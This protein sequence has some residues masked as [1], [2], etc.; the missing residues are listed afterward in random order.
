MVGT[1]CEHF[2]HLKLH[3]EKKMEVLNTKICHYETIVHS[4]KLLSRPWGNCFIAALSNGILKIFDCKT[5]G[6]AAEL[7]AHSR[8]INGLVCH[9]SKPI[10]AT[11]SDDTMTNVWYAKSEE[12]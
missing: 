11:V 6:L 8:S 5:G 4:I 10:F 3:A 1:S 9:S 2:L 7:M 12:N